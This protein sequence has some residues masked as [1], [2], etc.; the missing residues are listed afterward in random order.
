MINLFSA[1]FSLLKP[2][3]VRPSAFR[4][5]QQP[6]FLW[7][8][9]NNWTQSSSTPCLAYYMAFWP[10][11]TSCLFCTDQRSTKAKISRFGQNEGS[12]N[13]GTGCNII[14]SV[15]TKLSQYWLWCTCKH[16]L[17][18]PREEIAFTARPKIQSK[19]QI[20]RYG[21]SIFC[22]PHQPNFSDIFDL[23][24]HWVSV[25]R[26]FHALLKWGNSVFT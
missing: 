22:L 3:C 10:S 26:G 16:G 6:L 21:R 19:S 11:P 9:M 7:S 8:Q 13:H 14:W 25:V 15:N 2:L 1:G 23:C 17:R 5:L 20:L 18:T 4:A 12:W 24:L